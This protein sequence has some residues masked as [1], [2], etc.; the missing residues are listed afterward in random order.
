MDAVNNPFSPGAGNPPPALAGRGDIVN[1]AMIALERIRNGRSAQNMMLVGLRGVGKTVL[2]KRIE[3]LAKGQGYIV[4]KV[5]AEENKDLP[6][7]LYPHI[8]QAL[9]SLDF[10]QNVSAKVKRGLRVLKSFLGH[11]KIKSNDVEV[12]FD[13]DAERGT[14][15]SGI[16][17]ADFAQLLIALAEA[18]QDRKTAI[19]IIIDEL[20]YVSETELGSL[21]MSAHMIA[22]SSL[23]VIV[24]GAGLPQLVGA[25]G[26]ARSYAERL[27][28]FPEIG[29]LDLDDARKALQEPAR[30]KGVDFTDEALDE[31]L[32]VTRCYPYFLQEWAY[33]AWDIAD[34]S[35]ITDDVVRRATDA[36]IKHLDESFFRVRFDRL[37]PREKQYLRALADLGASAQRSGDIAEKMGVAVNTVAPVRNSLIKKGMIY[38]PA[39][40][41]TAFTVPLFDQF[42]KRT[43]P[44]GE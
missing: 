10:G 3:N 12:G 33:Q 9:F 44:G 42:M 16:L 4:L 34:A 11:V 30:T 15:D 5:E 13:F 36:A 31:I 35:P 14:A 39:H 38:S 7:L 18:A 2:L 26:K 19:C 25:A 23:P 27:F 1:R 21:I 32:R 41:D 17:D 43:M 29:P 20:Q 28:E 24:I 40:G 22:Q 6:T 8:R 37:T